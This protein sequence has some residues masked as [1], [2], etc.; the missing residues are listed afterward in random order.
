MCIYILAESRKI[1]SLTEIVEATFLDSS[2]NPFPQIQSLPE[3][4]LH[5]CQLPASML[6]RS[7]FRLPVLCSDPVVSWVLPWIVLSS[8]SRTLYGPSISLTTFRRP[9]GLSP[10]PRWTQV[11]LLGVLR[12][13]T[14]GCIPVSLRCLIIACLCACLPPFNCELPEGRD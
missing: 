2:Q 5:C 13:P 3:P 11:S 6:S 12:Y 4:P 8:L 9:L 1:W 7:I 14:R 10:S